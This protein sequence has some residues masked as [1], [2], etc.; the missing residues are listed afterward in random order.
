MTAEQKHTVHWLGAGLSSGPGILRLAAIGRKLVL[1]NRT[2][3]K[4]DALVQQIDYGDATARELNWDQLCEA[5]QPGDVVV[6]SDIPLADRC[7][8]AGA[9]V[10]GHN[11]AVLDQANIG[12]RLAMR[13]LMKDI[14]AS[15]PFHQSGGSSFSKADRS[16]F[17]QALD[18]ALTAAT[19]RQ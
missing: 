15:D 7:L 6:T 5:I 18:K 10:L 16:R 2:L 3:S 4:A 19:R 13:D 1:W 14:R 9:Q 12:N 11:G 17:L 8:K